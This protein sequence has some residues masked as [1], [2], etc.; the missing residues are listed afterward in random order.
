MAWSVVVQHDTP[1]TKQ[2]ITIKEPATLSPETFGQALYGEQA[3]KPMVKPYLLCASG[4]MF[5]PTTCQ[6]FLGHCP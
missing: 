4:K 1:L 2:L 6:A 3:L 5:K